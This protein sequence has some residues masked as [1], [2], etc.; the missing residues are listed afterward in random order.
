MSLVS[1]L[2][3]RAVLSAAAA[4]CCSGC[5]AAR[6]AASCS[7]EGS[8]SNFSISRNHVRAAVKTTEHPGWKGTRGESHLEKKIP[9]IFPKERIHRAGDSP[10]SF[11][12]QLFSSQKL[13]SQ[14]FGADIP[15][16][17]CVPRNRKRISEYTNSVPWVNDLQTTWSR[18]NLHF[19]SKKGKVHTW[20]EDGRNNSYIWN[21]ASTISA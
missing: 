7:Y 2:C 11:R 8:S 13:K 1:S 14:M 9:S 18:L 16:Q 3:T 4:A 12:E 6:P 20:G 10:S 21:Q 5:R 15:I 17:I 19:T